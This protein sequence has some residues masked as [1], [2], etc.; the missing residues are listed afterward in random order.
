MNQTSVFDYRDNAVYQAVSFAGGPNQLPSYCCAYK[1]G[2]DNT[3]P[4]V[5]WQATDKTSSG[6]CNGKTVDF[7]TGYG[8]TL[9]AYYFSGVEMGYDPSNLLIP[10]CL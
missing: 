10:M 3:L 4:S 9:S 8:N 6:T 7:Y 1:V 2:I 5:F